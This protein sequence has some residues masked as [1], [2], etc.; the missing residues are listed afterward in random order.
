MIDHGFAAVRA[1]LKDMHRLHAESLLS[2]TLI[3]TYLRTLDLIPPLR[4]LIRAG[5]IQAPRRGRKWRLSP[6]SPRISGFPD[7]PAGTVS[8]DSPVEALPGARKEA[9]GAVRLWRIR[10]FVRHT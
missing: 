3:K 5:L 8:I 7:Y 6:L 4:P 9:H 10:S 2:R 1:S